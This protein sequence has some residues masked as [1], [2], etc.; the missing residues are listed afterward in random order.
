MPERNVFFVILLCALLWPVTVQANPRAF[1][2]E[3]YKIEAFDPPS[4]TGDLFFAQ[5]GDA[6]P[7]SM[8]AVRGRW[9]V[10][11]LW[12]TW[13]APCVAELPALNRLARVQDDGVDVLAVSVDRK[14]NA[15]RIAYYLKRWRVEA[16]TPLH[17]TARL[18]PS[19]LDTE[20]LP[21]TYLIDPKGRVRVA[22]YGRAKWD[23][24]QAAD[25]LAGL[26]K[27]PDFFMPYVKK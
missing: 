3:F 25:F 9:T 27:D 17:D 8:A 15:D 13:C 6:A 10:L 23:G 18:L 19:R 21:V 16:I 11:N 5:P 7:F 2:A 14:M 24:Q 4:G 26:Q 22:L 12:A 20:R 1:L